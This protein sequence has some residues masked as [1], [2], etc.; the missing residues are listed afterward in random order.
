MIIEDVL[1]T[2][3][4][5]QS[6]RQEA[7]HQLIYDVLIDPAERLNLPSS[8]IEINAHELQQMRIFSQECPDVNLCKRMAKLWH[9]WVQTEGTEYS[10]GIQGTWT[11]IWKLVTLMRRIE[12]A[13]TDY[14]AMLLEP[15]PLPPPSAIL[16][17]T[18][19]AVVATMSFEGSNSVIGPL[20]NRNEE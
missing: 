16:A 6:S 3:G 12:D 15:S 20:H 5:N 13:N 19:L 11:R 7:A 14:I 17:P 1:D 10:H 4:G 9:R 18:P 8:L 2:L